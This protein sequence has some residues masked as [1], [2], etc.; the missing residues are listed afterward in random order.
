[1]PRLTALH[2]ARVARDKE[3][4]WWAQDVARFRAERAKKSISLNEAERRAERDRLEA[5]R[6]QREAER[7]ALGLAA[8][9][10]SDDDGLQADERDVARQVEQEE[11]AKKRPDPLLRESAAILADAITVLSGNRE[12]TLQVRPVS[13]QPTHWTD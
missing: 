7:V 4:S 6:K 10:S 2:E 3:Y 11:A 9:E 1:V 12:L 5:R 13:K 8:D